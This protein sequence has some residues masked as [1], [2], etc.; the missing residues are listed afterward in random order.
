MFMAWVAISTTLLIGLLTV[1]VESAAGEQFEVVGVVDAAPLPAASSPSEQ[2]PSVVYAGMVWSLTESRVI[3]RTEDAFSRPWIVVELLATNIADDGELRVR[4]G[5]LSIVMD[6]GSNHPTERLER[7]A[8]SSRF[9]VSPGK[10]KAV[11]AV[12]ELRTNRD[13]NPAD[14]QL[15]IAEPGRIPAF[16]PLVGEPDEPMYPVEADIS[17]EPATITDPDDPS[18]QLILVPDS[19]SVDIETGPYR[20]AMGERLSVIEVSVQRAAVD[21]D[22]AYLHPEFWRLDVGTERLTPIRVVRVGQSAVNTDGIK[23]LFVFVAGP[24]E[25]TLT[26]AANTDN[27]VAYAITTPDYSEQ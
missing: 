15:Q 19:A 23:L 17:D 25:M 7:T 2:Y 10:T 24:T 16:L 1:G 11:T 5:D 6:D 4:E 26:A 21:N 13:P 14:L 3:P 9:S 22:A 18:R 8:S 12:F 20:A 27:P